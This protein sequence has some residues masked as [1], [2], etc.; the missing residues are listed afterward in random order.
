MTT[1]MLM[2][3]VVMAVSNDDPRHVGVSCQHRGRRLCGLH[4]LTVW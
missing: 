4:F 2:C 1:A 3:A